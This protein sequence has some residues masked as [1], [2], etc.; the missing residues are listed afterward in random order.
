M[1]YRESYGYEVRRKNWRKQFVGKTA[2]SVL[3]LNRDIKNIS[4]ATLSCRHVTEG[5]KQVLAL[6]DLVLR[7]Q[8]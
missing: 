7:K 4:G 1:E 2:A 3:K 6:Y 5:I 8:N